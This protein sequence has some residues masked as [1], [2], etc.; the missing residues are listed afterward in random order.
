MRRRILAVPAVVLALLAT[1][2]R[3]VAP[4]TGPTQLR[5]VTTRVAHVVNPAEVE[6]LIVAL[7]GDPSHESAMLSH[8]ANIRKIVEGGTGSL[9]SLESHVNNSVKFT[10]EDLALNALVDPDGTGP[11]IPATGAARLLGWIFE[12]SGIYPTVLPAVPAGTDAF[13]AFVDPTATE[14]QTFVTSFGDA[15][16]VVPP[17]SFQD[18]VLLMAVRQ[19]EAIQVNTPY[20]KLSR[21]FDISIAPEVDFATMSVLMCPL[22]GVSDE[23]NDRAVLAH[24]VD[25]ATVE[26]LSR[27][28]VAGD[29]TCPHDVASAW[30]EKSGFLAQRAAQAASV[31]RSAW[32]LVGPKPLYAGH[33][34]IGGVLTSLSPVVAVDPFLGT[35]ITPGTVSSVTYGSN[36]TV[37]A[38]LAVSAGPGI[39]IGTAVAGAAVTGAVDGGSPQQATTDASG[40]VSFTFSGLG[41]GTH[42]VTFSFAG[43]LTPQNAP[44]YGGATASVTFAV[45]PAPLTITANNASREY[46]QP[47]PTFTGS[48]SGVQGG[49]VITLGFTTT[50]TTTSLPGTY[51]IVP[52]ASGAALG[53]YVVTTVKG[54]LTIRKIPVTV[55]VAGGTYVYGT[56]AGAICQPA[57]SAAVNAAWYAGSLTCT[58]N[59]SPLPSIP[60]VGTYVITTAGLTSSIYEFT[61]GSATVTVKYNDTV[62]HYFISPIPNTQ[63]QQG[64]NVPAKFQLF[65]A[66][67]TTP[68]TNATASATVRNVSSGALL[69]FSPTTFSYSASTKTYSLGI[70]LPADA[71]PGFYVVTA[72]LDD[73]SKIESPIEIKAR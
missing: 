33:A 8:W 41:A 39:F 28:G 34:A 24:Q 20:P 2:C 18:P 15:G 52:V 68:V 31:I 46:G 62:G 25:A 57:F 26:Y 21:T 9:S 54:T 67:G 11:L 63:Y 10:L 27:S 17:A 70:K 16:V 40:N 59:G 47:N 72:H 64:R 66:N 51:D 30:R 49:D 45:D 13:F 43:M 6:A 19:P 23:V 55:T 44:E 71:P 1:S 56:G 37:S 65:M 42:S 61:F 29:I 7:F 3:D 36:V 35:T 38:N 22:E 48:I 69:A 73:G 50:A 5:R 53:N 32:Q 58:V 14:N 60:P 4:P 12:Y